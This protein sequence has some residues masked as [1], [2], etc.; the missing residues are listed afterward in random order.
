MKL[1]QSPTFILFL[2]AVIQL[3][4][5]DSRAENKFGV[6]TTPEQKDVYVR[7]NM[8]KVRIAA[9]KY[10]S[11]HQ[12]KFP[13]A[14][15]RAFQS[16]MPYGGCD[17]VNCSTLSC[18]YN[19]CTSMK[20]LPVL[21]QIKNVHL[22]RKSLPG[23]LSAGVVEYSAID[24]G[25]DYA[26]RGG[27]SYGKALAEDNSGGKRTLVVSSDILQSIL[28]NMTAVQW[29]AEC[30]AEDHHGLYP[31]AIDDSFKK[32]FPGSDT[33]HT[34]AGLPLM[35]PATKKLEWPVLGSVQDPKKARFVEPSVMAPGKIEYS[36]IN[37][38]KDYAIR[39][40]DA[41][42]KMIAKGHGAIKTLVLSKD[43]Q[44]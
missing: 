31:T 28:A 2:L 16:Y 36:P 21:G 30:Y 26:I 4:L 19:P 38:G 42:G 34:K 8:M 9:E 25:K 3:S 40:G 39:A 35:N 24:G 37:N 22:A 27:N 13:T 33:A 6:P 32:Y 43:G 5:A 1:L 15:D 41:R 14:I 7:G 20:E 18:L 10:A 11:H 44:L 29:A 23:P 12:G 17:D